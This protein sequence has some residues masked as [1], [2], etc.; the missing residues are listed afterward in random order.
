MSRTPQQ[1]QPLARR[2]LAGAAGVEA[3]AAGEGGGGRGE[4]G[5]GGP[6]VLMYMCGFGH[7][8]E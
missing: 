7:V 5:G 4:E 3:A 2:A 1:L 6:C 8:S